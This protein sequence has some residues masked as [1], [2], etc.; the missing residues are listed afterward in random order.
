[1][2]KFLTCLEN[3]SSN[4]KQDVRH[5]MQADS[6]YEFSRNESSRLCYDSCINILTTNKDEKELLFDVIDKI[7]DT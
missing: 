1:M 6:N 7:Q 5:Q 3:P 4:N 2:V